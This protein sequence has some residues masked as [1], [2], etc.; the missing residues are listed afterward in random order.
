[1]QPDN[2]AAIATPHNPDLDLLRHDL[3]SEYGQEHHRAAIADN[4]SNSGDAH[5]R[6]YWRGRRDAYLEDHAHLALL[7]GIGEAQ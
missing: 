1:M 5:Q 6:S 4:Y 2:T 3:L 7:L